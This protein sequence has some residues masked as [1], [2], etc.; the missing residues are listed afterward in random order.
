MSNSLA[1]R[2]RILVLQAD[3]HRNLIE[4]EQLR[5]QQRFEVLRGQMRAKSWWLLG[6][7]VVTG[8]LTTRVFGS[9]LKF[10]PAG[11]AAWRLIQ[12]FTRR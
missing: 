2:K 1:E 12:N 9:L 3:V 7:A 6:A 8:W 11:M 10:V 4:L 5:L